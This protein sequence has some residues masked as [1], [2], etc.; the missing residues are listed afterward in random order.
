MSPSGGGGGSSGGS[1]V[2]NGGVPNGGVTNG[3]VSGG[4]GVSSNTM[5]EFQVVPEHGLCNEFIEL[6][7]GTP[8]NHVLNA[9]KSASR[10]IRN[11]EF[12]Y[13]NKV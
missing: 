1:S 6:V 10:V 4:G 12:V 13:C 8:I 2:T 11:V 5:L 9:L 3:G 7:L